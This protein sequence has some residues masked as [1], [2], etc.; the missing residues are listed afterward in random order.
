M[1]KIFCN[2]LNIPGERKFKNKTPEYYH[3]RDFPF[4]KR[5]EIE[6]KYDDYFKFCFVRNPWDR[7]VSCYKHWIVDSNNDNFGM[8][9]SLKKGM[10]FEEF[11]LEISKI[12]DKISDGHFRSQHTFIT[13]K[14]GKLLVDFFGKVEEFDK[15]FAFICKKT[16]IPYV[17]IPHSNRR[18]RRPYRDFYNERTRGIVEKRYG[19][20]IKLFG[21]EF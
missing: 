5:S 16:G 11:V 15:D 17:E 2:V 14:N 6:N 4:V 9:N 3:F 8:Y 7:L 10:S 21:Y 18:D 20:D 13:N 19:K 1:K 12:P